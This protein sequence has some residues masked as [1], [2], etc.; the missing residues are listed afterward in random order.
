MLRQSSKTVIKLEQNLT[1]LA[2]LHQWLGYQNTKEILADLSQSKEGFDDNGSSYILKRLI[3]RYSIDS[4]KHPELKKYDAHIREVLTEMN[5]GRVESVTLRYFQYLAAL[6]TEIYLDFRWN[7]TDRF[8]NSLNEFVRE[9]KLNPSYEFILSDLDKIAFW[10]ATGSG[11]TLLL[12]LN[13]HQFLHYNNETLDNIILITPNERLSEQHL[14][15]MRQSNIPCCRF[16]PD[17]LPIIHGHT[18]QVTEITKLVMEGRGKGERVSVE[19]FEGNN[20]IFV[21]EGHKGS[22]GVAWRQVR[23]A[24]GMT[25]FTFEYS[26]TFGQ[27]LTAARNRKLTAEYGKAIVFDYSYGHFYQD[28]YGKDFNILNLIQDPGGHRDIL[29]LASLLTFHEQ[30]SVFQDN[31]YRIRLYNIQKPLWALVGG[32]VNAIYS[33][34]GHKRSDVLEVLC[35]L[36]RF[37]SDRIWAVES[38]KNLLMG[39][40]GLQNEGVDLFEGRF[41]Y[42]N[43]RSE[44]SI[45]DEIVTKMF[46]APYAGGLVLSDL[47][48]A[49]GEIG[50]KVAGSDQ[51]F[52]VISIGD[53]SKFKKYFITK[54]NGIVVEDDVISGSLFKYIN[55]SEANINILI[56]SRKFLEGWNSWRISNMGLLNIG[57]SEGA[58]IIQL[59]GRGVRLLGLNQTLRRSASIDGTKH[60]RF[61]QK[62]ETLNVFAL[63][64]DYMAKFREYIKQEGAEEMIEIPIPTITNDKWLDKDLVIPQLDK[65]RNFGAETQ[66]ILGNDGNFRVRLDVRAHTQ[67]IASG[68]DMVVEGKTGKKRSMQ[69]IK[70]VLDFVNWNDVYLDVSRYV[71]KRGYDNIAI[72]PLKLRGIMEDESSFEL[73]ADDRIIQPFKWKDIQDFQ[74]VAVTILR[75]Y[76]DRHY[77]NHRTQWESRHMIYQKLERN[78]P[79]LKFNTDLGESDANY[80]VK[81]PASQKEIVAEIKRLTQLDDLY[82]SDGDQPP[83][84]IFDRHLY[85]PLLI[86]HIGEITASPPPL[87]KGE[88]TFIKDLRNYWME[89]LSE[90]KKEIFLLRNLSRGQGVGFFESYGFYPDF[91]IWVKDGNT[92]RIVFVEPHGMVYAHANPVDEKA[93]LY[94]QLKE[95]QNKLDHPDFYVELDSFIVSTTPF[96]DLRDRYADGSW[97]LWKFS[98][99]HILFQER[100][101]NNGYDYIAEILKVEKR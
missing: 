64:A 70:K 66:W 38:L 17:G 6:Y 16:R 3:S 97:D 4:E 30:Q 92:Q 93:Q 55:E 13:F 60:P 11:K 47:R 80:T 44:D 29:L 56:G 82:K 20:L 21:D 27:A 95:L 87:N 99:N 77:R 85:Q 83:R 10:M 62:L 39:N 50:L 8:L 100:D 7:H 84:I 78:N 68:E 72:D 35:F 14:V 46:N 28:G 37:L 96:Q 42:F 48:D 73:F 24:I 36:H 65:G 71:N 52:G 43:E 67:A 23:D 25:G 33:E 40:S 26:A 12:H 75:K 53:T 86:E 18:I 9:R 1:L 94:V 5:K 90:N 19:A 63:R 69:E 76:V 45:Y 81:V 31:A 58:Q 61:I 89:E 57:R 59:F 88:F 15:D 2:W 74:S 32:S 98:K 49:D 54:A 41:S 79:N 51:Y 22:G 91:I 34:Q 101:T